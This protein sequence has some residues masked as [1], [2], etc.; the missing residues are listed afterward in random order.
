MI[1]ADIQLADGSSGVDAV[2]VPDGPRAQSRMGALLSAVPIER[3]VG[4]EA[5]C[6]YGCSDRNHHRPRTAGRLGRGRL[7]S[8]QTASSDRH[9]GDDGDPMWTT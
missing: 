1:L 6:H 3:E 2:N 7:K 9:T 5:V 8:R 4:L